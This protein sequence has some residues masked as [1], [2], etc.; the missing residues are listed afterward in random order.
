MPEN[1]ENASCS[2]NFK[3]LH[4]PHNSQKYV[5]ILH[6]VNKLGSSERNF[7]FD[8][9]SILATHPPQDFVFVNNTLNW[10]SP[11]ELSNSLSNELIYNITIIEGDSIQYVLSSHSNIDFIGFKP[12]TIYTFNISCKMNDS[13]NENWSEIVSISNRTLPSSIISKTLFYYY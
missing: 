3:S 8:Q 11:R 6:A 7:Y 5:F 9:K 2:W 4:S 12:Y 1:G 10:T 13:S